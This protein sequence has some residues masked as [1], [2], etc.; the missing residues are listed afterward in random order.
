MKESQTVVKIDNVTCNRR[1]RELGNLG[2]KPRFIAAQAFY[3]KVIRKLEPF[4]V[5]AFLVVIMQCV[6]LFSSPKLIS[7]NYIL[8]QCHIL[9]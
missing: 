6:K 5:T 3:L 1:R 9:L 8:N 2:L 4:F 7:L